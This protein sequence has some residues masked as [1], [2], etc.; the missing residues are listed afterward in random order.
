MTD[1]EQVLARAAAGWQSAIEARDVKGVVDF[2]HEDY[3]L[4]LVVPA[5]V[6]MP[7][8][9]WVRALA[10]YVV[11]AYDMHEQIADVTRDTAV[12]LTLASQERPSWARTAVAASS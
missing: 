12:V 11:H 9:E 4:V 2:L 6:T 3:A 10:D 1:F 5:A 8:Q 7:R